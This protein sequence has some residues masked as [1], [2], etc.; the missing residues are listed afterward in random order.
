MLLTAGR[1][2]ASWRRSL[3]KGSG[4][5]AG[6][7]PRWRS[8]WPLSSRVMSLVAQAKD[9]AERLGA[10]EHEAGGGADAG[11]G[12]VVGDVAAQQG[13]AAVLGDRFALGEAE[14]G[15]LP[16]RDVVAGHGPGE[17]AAGALPGVDGL[18]C[19]PGVEV[20]LGE[21]RGVAA[22]CV[23][24]GEEVLGLDKSLL[25]VF[26]GF[27]APQQ[28]AS[29]SLAVPRPDPLSPVRSLRARTR[30]PTPPPG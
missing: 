8:S 2:V 19:V 9:A 14:L 3:A 20:G 12:V 4:A 6:G 13:E 28:A 29:R 16:G 10:E 17:E 11:G 23:G 18:G 5:G 22:E 25:G 30:P 26:A 24:P 15:E 27:T 7:W 21:V 1:S